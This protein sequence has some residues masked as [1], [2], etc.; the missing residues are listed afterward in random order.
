[1]RRYLLIFMICLLSHALVQAGDN[2][3][4]ATRDEIW[5]QDPDMYNPDKA[6]NQLLPNGYR[7]LHCQDDVVPYPRGASMK[8]IEE[9]ALDLRL[10]KIESP[11]G[12]RFLGLAEPLR[13]GNMLPVY[14]AI[15]G[16]I[17]VFYDYDINFKQIPLPKELKGC[18]YAPTF[19]MFFDDADARWSKA[20]GGKKPAYQANGWVNLSD[21]YAWL[22]QPLERNDFLTF[23]AKPEF[24][25]ENIW[26]NNFDRMKIGSATVR[27]ANGRKMTKTQETGGY[28]IDTYV[29]RK[30]AMSYT[31][32][33][34]NGTLKLKFG[35]KISS[36]SKVDWHNW[37]G[38]KD[39]YNQNDFDNVN[40]GAAYMRTAAPKW[41]A[42]SPTPVW[43]EVT[44][45][46]YA[47]TPEFMVV[48][49]YVVAFGYNLTEV[50]A[51]EG[52]KGGILTL[53]R[54]RD[55]VNGLLDDRKQNRY[56]KS[57]ATKRVEMQQQR[58]AK[59]K[60]DV[61]SV[62]D[63]IAPCISAYLQA[64]SDGMTDYLKKNGKNA[65]PAHAGGWITQFI[66]ER[67]ETPRYKSLLEKAAGS[68][69]ILEAVSQNADLIDLAVKSKD[70][71]PYTSDS[72]MV[73]VLMG[74]TPTG[75]QILEI[76]IKY[77]PHPRSNDLWEVTG[78]L[79]W[80]EATPVLENYNKIV[81]II[82]GYDETTMKAL[83][84]HCGKEL[85]ALK[86]TPRTVKE[87][88]EAGRAYLVISEYLKAQK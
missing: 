56:K 24:E 67:F 6:T 74:G 72:T 5:L 64:C 8:T 11:D 20:H 37:E 22:F 12:H 78:E 45:T 50:W 60:T 40:P 13:D 14:G 53:P 48:S 83:K 16:D 46:V 59:A 19:N 66:A 7:L 35:S 84:K 79:T 71:M 36:R 27:G 82:N 69:K 80:S 61:Q 26:T 17:L 4:D 43:G 88:N 65:N 42:Q 86:N 87:T 54:R 55:I 52:T 75:L 18:W 30:Y 73:R 2:W 25:V 76:P 41:D 38:P 15:D 68:N 29:T 31:W 10:V 85:K 32:D 28:W 49:G 57:R 21:T 81:E 77:S 23:G 34:D 58:E 70:F 62:N 51:L 47:V 44:L 33:P 1:M 9:M 3:E 63:A 39:S